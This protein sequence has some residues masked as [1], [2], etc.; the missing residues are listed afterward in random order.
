MISD[1][2]E[3]RRPE[4]PPLDPVVA[5][6]LADVDRSLIAKNLRLSVEERFI[7]LMEL[8]RFA[9]EPGRGGRAASENA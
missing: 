1:P 4:C 2:V 5:A 7:Q 3:S 9:Q 8:Q 6:Y